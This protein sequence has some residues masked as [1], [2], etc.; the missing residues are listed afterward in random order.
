MQRVS[1]TNFARLGRALLA[2]SIVVSL[3]ALGLASPA[4]AIVAPKSFS[5]SP[6]VVPGESGVVAVK[7]PAHQKGAYPLKGLKAAAL[8]YVAP[9]ERGFTRHIALYGTDKVPAVVGPVRSLRETDFPVLDQFGKVRVYASGRSL[10]R[11]IMLNLLSRTKHILRVNSNENL[12]EMYFAPGCVDPFCDFLKGTKIAGRGTGLSMSN[13][14][15]LKEAGLSTGALPASVKSTAKS[16][17]SMKIIYRKTP[18]NDP[19]PR[20]I[21]WNASKKVWIYEA[22]GRSAT[23]DVIGGKSVAGQTSSASAIIQFTTAKNAGSAFTCRIMPEGGPDAVPYTN[24]VGKGLG[25]L[26]RD[27]KIYDITW[28]RS[29]STATTSYKFKNGSKVKVT[30]QPWI[31]LVPTNLTTGSVTYSNGAKVAF[32]PKPSTPKWSF[33]TNV[34]KERKSCEA[35]TAIKVSKASA[36][37]TTIKVTSNFDNLNYVP[38]KGLKVKVKIT[39]KGYVTVATSPAGTVTVKAE[40]SKVTSATIAKQTV[41]GQ[42]YAANS[43]KK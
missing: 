18:Y 13:A 15:I 19:I 6:D 37:S 8:I 23:V 33:S 34:L 30:G 11:D 4:S 42:K 9:V 38:V 25:F 35:P 10:E 1:S 39:G 24:S 31:Y 43:W 3:S 2:T 27:G 12:R 14:N 20:T 17:K 21:T 7:V 40:S 16:I 22:S 29:S 26:L 32:A 36:T 41:A 5:T 28:S